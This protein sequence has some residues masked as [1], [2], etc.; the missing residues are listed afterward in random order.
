[1]ILPPFPLGSETTIQFAPMVS[2]VWTRSSTSTGTKTTIIS[3]QP[4][5]TDGIP[6]WPVI[7]GADA[8]PTKFFPLQSFMPQSSIVTLPED[9]TPFSP[10]PSGSATPR[11][12][13]PG[14]SHIVT[15]QPQATGSVSTT[16]SVPSISWST[17][18]PADTCTSGCGIDSCKLF[19]RCDSSNPVDDCGLFACGGGCSIQGCSQS[20]GL[21]CSTDQH[22][23]DS[24]SGSG[25]I[26]SQPG[27]LPMDYDG[28][29][30]LPNGGW[31][32]IPIPSMVARSVTSLLSAHFAEATTNSDALVHSLPLEPYAKSAAI[33]TATSLKEATST[34]VSNL[35]AKIKKADPDH[36]DAA[37]KWFND[38]FS[39][40]VNAIDTAVRAIKE[41]AWQSSHQLETAIE[42][43][44]NDVTQI[45][46]GAAIEADE[47]ICETPPL[48]FFNVLSD[49]LVVPQ[50]CAPDF[51]GN[52]SEASNKARIPNWVGCE[53][54]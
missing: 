1:M 5:V 36:S 29:N 3:V 39:D 18:N 14:T 37:M 21:S 45:N 24:D 41:E 31:N 2:S 20:C 17:G 30:G 43:A 11:P 54:R 10:V 50:S 38:L 28:P 27:N 19:G 46:E 47:D 44:D 8:T 9:E 34:Q 12:V 15:I 49:K 13:F 16:I 35:N 48:H 6:F 52:I 22:H 40:F 53:Q 33:R 25:S 26:E 42:R 32:P 23:I 7:V 51:Q 4:L